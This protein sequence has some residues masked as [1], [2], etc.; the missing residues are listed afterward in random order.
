LEIYLPVEANRDL[1]AQQD[2]ELAEAQ[3]R[4]RELAAAR[5]MRDQR[6]DALR[7]LE[8]QR[9]AYM[10]LQIDMRQA[11][12]AALLASL[13]QP[14]PPTEGVTISFL[15]A[16]PRVERVFPREA[17]LATLTAFVRGSPEL[18]NR[19]TLTDAALM[20]G[21]ER[22]PTE[23]QSI[24]EAF[25]G[26]RRVAV[27]IIPTEDEDEDGKNPHINEKARPCFC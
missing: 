8:E 22:L 7:V 25:P 14:P 20:G 18:P 1:R 17:D 26:R 23:G 5:A 24:G 27:R 15:S 6:E 13:P 9:R 4:D 11:E 21:Q 2:A 3:R 10:A 16:A 12:Q 19:F